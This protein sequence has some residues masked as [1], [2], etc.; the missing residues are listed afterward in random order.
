MKESDLDVRLRERDSED[1]W[2]W[3]KVT[4]TEGVEVSL[5]E[6]VDDCSSVDVAESDEL[7][8]CECVTVRLPL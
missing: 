7:I 5:I 3:D 1:T 6:S 2:E 8:V 4:V